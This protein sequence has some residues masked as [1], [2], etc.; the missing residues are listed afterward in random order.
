MAPD[1]VNGGFRLWD[2]PNQHNSRLDELGE[3][4]YREI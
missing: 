4:G 2:F 1:A 3:N